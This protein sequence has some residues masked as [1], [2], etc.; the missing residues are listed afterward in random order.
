MSEAKGCLFEVLQLPL[1][2]RLQLRTETAI[3][4]DV[5]KFHH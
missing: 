1:R 2:F 5:S 4:F 3:L